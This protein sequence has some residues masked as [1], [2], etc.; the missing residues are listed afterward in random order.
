MNQ[1]LVKVILVLA[2]ALLTVPSAAKAKKE[3][4]S[5]D[6]LF[7]IG[8][9]PSKIKFDP[10]PAE[11]F[12]CTGLLEER[13]KLWVF[14][15]HKKDEVTFYYVY[16]LIEADFGAGPTGEFE[17]QNDDGI[18]VA[19]APKG[20]KEIGAGYALSPDPKARKMAADIGV[21]D[22]VLSALLSD[23]IAREVK[24]FGG[25]NNFLAK[26][27]EAGIPESSLEPQ[28]RAKLHALKEQ[29]GA[30]RGATSTPTPL[31]NIPVNGIR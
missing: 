2:I 19:V 15:K 25:V 13:R 11:V 22:D 24:A 31:D 14:G 12:R 4:R 9:S 28:V 7:G 8:Y 3:L 30:K 5:S 17:A 6:P 23:L 16:G 26:V 21:T 20:C 18:I 27:K 29:A 1:R 10:A